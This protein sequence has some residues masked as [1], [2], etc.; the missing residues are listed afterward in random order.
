MKRVITLLVLVVIGLGS[1]QAQIDYDNE[2]RNGSTLVTKKPGFVMVYGVD[3]NGSTYDFIV[4]VKEV[5]DGLTFDYEMTNATGTKGTVHITEDALDDALTQNNYFS[6]GKLDLSDQTSVWVSRKILQDLIEDGETFVSP[7]GG[8]TSTKLVQK[9][10]AHDYKAM[11]SIS[12]EMMEEISYV[13]A[14]SP[15][16]SIKYW[17]HLSKSNPIILRMELGWSIWLKEIRK[18]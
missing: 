10:V 8:E 11:N 7:D 14:E 12:E 9:K 6:G 13:Y 4:R 18:E 17:I 15:D 3:F 2:L 1:S 5:E 16:G